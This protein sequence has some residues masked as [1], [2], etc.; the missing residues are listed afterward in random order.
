[1]DALHLSDRLAAVAAYVPDGARLADIGSDH[2]YLPANLLL[3]QRINFAIAGEVAKGPLQ[4]AEEEIARHHLTDVLKPRLADGLAA[5]MPEDD[6]DTV[7]IAGM[8]GRLITNILE[9]GHQHGEHYAHLILQANTDVAAVR[10]WL[11]KHH[12][13]ITAERMILD[14]G[15]YYEI[16]VAEPGMAEYSDQALQFGPLNIA[17]QASVWR[18]YWQ[19]EQQRLQSIMQQLADQN[20]QQSAAYANYAQQVAQIQEV[21]THASE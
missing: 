4:N 13:R 12:Y 11:M 17:E 8:G 9:A 16:V 7:V 21:L 5:V 19:R 1:M 2:A 6:I 14:D 20:Q 15:H 18:E 10:S 3:N